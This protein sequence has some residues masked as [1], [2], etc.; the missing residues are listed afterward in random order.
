[1]KMKRWLLPA[2]AAVLLVAGC[3]SGGGGGSGSSGPS[4][5]AVSSGGASGSSGGSSGAAS[6]NRG[7]PT[8]LKVFASFMPS[9]EYDD[10]YYTKFI[11][12][13]FNVKFE[14]NAATRETFEEKKKL[15]MASGDYPDIFMG[16][17][18]FTLQELMLYG[19]QGI[20]EPLN[21]LIDKYGENIK[22]VV[23][24]EYPT[25]LEAITAPDGSFTTAP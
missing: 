5:G 10:G 11:E 4:G 20:L 19:Q 2:L 23:L 6:Q 3:T 24:P 25:F 13:K 16:E 18:L 14:W 7:A 9:D 8:V 17:S 12:E 15:V 22:N 1:M 21:D